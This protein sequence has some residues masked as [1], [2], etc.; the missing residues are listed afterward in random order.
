MG[1]IEVTR[2]PE[3]KKV[4]ETLSQ[5]NKVGRDDVRLLSQEQR[6]A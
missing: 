4:E 6:E 3:Q 5:W 2:H 1:K